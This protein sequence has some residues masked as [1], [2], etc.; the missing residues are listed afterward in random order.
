MST[1]KIAITI[2]DKLVEKIDALVKKR[3]FPNRSR[4]IQEAVAEKLSRLD[5]SRLAKEC[6]KLDKVFEQHLTE[7]GLTSEIELWPEY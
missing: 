6:S 4:A 3:I 5:K 7:E 2:D 1:A